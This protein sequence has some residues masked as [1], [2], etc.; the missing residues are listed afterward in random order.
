MVPFLVIQWLRLC[1]PN[2]RYPVS[3]P[4]QGTRSHMLQGKVPTTKTLHS[5]INKSFFKSLWNV[6]NLSN[7]YSPR[8][9]CSIPNPGTATLQDQGV[10]EAPQ[11]S[12]LYIFIPCPRPESLHTESV[13][14]PH[15]SVLIVQMAI[16]RDGDDMLLLAWNL[17]ARPFLQKH[18]L[19]HLSLSDKALT[20]QLRWPH[21]FAISC[22]LLLTPP[23]GR[24]QRVK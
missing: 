20:C 8:D 11:R 17:K 6:I 9:R 19:P 5:Q 15:R 7:R 18:S 2:A 24:I 21:P 14:S 13:C 23:S 16:A 3:I 1:G 22:L 12:I 10:L 4:G